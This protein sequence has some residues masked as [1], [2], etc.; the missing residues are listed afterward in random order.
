MSY[1]QVEINGYVKSSITKLPPNSRVYIKQL[2]S[3]KPVL[4]RMT[5]TDST[6]FFRIKNLEPNKRYELKLSSFG[7]QDQYFEIKTNSSI[8]KTTLT[9]EASCTYSKEQAIKDWKNKRAKLLLVGSI[10]PISNS[11]LDNR[12]EKKYNIKYFD[13]GCSPPIDECIK[14]YNEQIFVLMNEKYG[15]KW[16]K[17]V[18]S[19]VKF[20]N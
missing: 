20:L 2:K 8:T 14:I 15:P 18:R 17:K 10:A 5:M 4:E 6:G 3:E 16:R 11:T 12:F 1:S 13:F 9:L 7:Y 19:D